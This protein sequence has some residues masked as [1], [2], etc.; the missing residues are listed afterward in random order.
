VLADFTL[1][2]TVDAFGAGAYNFGEETLLAAE[3]PVKCLLGGAS[4]RG[5]D[6]HRGVVKA[7]LQKNT[8]RNCCNFVT[9]LLAARDSPRPQHFLWGPYVDIN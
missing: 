9:P 2:L 7:E 8:L 6:L 5:N 4:T 3:V 1:D